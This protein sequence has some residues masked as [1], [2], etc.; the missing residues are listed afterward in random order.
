[1]FLSNAPKN[2][3][4]ASQSNEVTDGD[5]GS[6]ALQ[7]KHLSATPTTF[8]RTKKTLNREETRS[9]DKKNINPHVRSKVCRYLLC[10]NTPARAATPAALTRPNTV[11]D[12]GS[13]DTQT[14][15]CKT[16]PFRCLS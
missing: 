16:R 10:S 4:S 9:K 11:D 8:K 5:G 3:S 12:V 2:V 6:E 15:C 7:I 13:E 1:V 14:I